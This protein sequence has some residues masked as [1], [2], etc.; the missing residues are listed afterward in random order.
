MAVNINWPQDELKISRKMHI[1]HNDIL[2]DILIRFVKSAF[3]ILSI[4]SVYAR[5]QQPTEALGKCL[6]FY[7]NANRWNVGVTATL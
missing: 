3:P 2:W 7:G 4:A 5:V 6:C 1:S